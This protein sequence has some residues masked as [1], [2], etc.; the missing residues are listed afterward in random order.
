V[1]GGMLGG[2][3]RLQLALPENGRDRARTATTRSSR[4]TARR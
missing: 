3:M 2:L 1:L 4:C